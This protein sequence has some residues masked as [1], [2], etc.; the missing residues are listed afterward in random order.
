VICWGKGD[1]VLK[2]DLKT[3]RSAG[4]KH[5][6]PVASNLL[7]VAKCLINLPSFLAYSTSLTIAKSIHR[8]QSFD[9]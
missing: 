6:T 2:K 9:Y 8:V 3:E 7:N 5:K 1:S 4:N